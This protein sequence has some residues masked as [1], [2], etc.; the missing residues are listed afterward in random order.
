MR[1]ALL[2]I[3]AAAITAANPN[4]QSAMKTCATQWK[5]MSATDQAKTT[6][7]AHMSACMK[8]PAAA[9]IGGMMVMTAKPAAPGGSMM[10]MA[11]KPATGGKAKCKD[12][13]IVTYEKRSGTCSGHKGVDSWL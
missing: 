6:Y 7:K 10:M 13:T 8:A 5:A 3:L 4:P 12:G 2:F 9:P 11:A 1:T